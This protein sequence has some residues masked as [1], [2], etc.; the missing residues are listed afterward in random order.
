MKKSK[1]IFGVVLMLCG[2]VGLLICAALS[3][4]HRFQNPDMT[5]LRFA[6]ENSRM[7][8]WIGLDVIFLFVGK[9]LFFHE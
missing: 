9:A 5:N 7:I 6:I 1:Q 2:L 8:F 3:L 4:A